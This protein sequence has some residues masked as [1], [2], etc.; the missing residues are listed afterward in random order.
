MLMLIYVYIHVIILRLHSSII[1][2]MR[3]SYLHRMRNTELK[4]ITK[5]N[6]EIHIIDIFFAN[7]TNYV[8]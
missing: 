6:N 3:E 1:S 7:P 5:Y 8:R 2:N 4:Y